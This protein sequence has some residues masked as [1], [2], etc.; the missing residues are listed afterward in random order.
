MLRLCREA[1]G[2]AREETLYVGDMALDVES[3]RQA[4]VPVV[5]V[6]GGSSSLDLLRGTGERVLS[7]LLDLLLLL[8]SPAPA[9]TGLTRDA[10]PA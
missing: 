4:G 3:A 5:L 6:P 1:L 2:T 7:G 10:E 9:A 8:P